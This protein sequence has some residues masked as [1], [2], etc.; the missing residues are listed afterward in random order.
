MPSAPDKPNKTALVL[1]GGGSLGAVQVGMLKALTRARVQYEFIVGASVGALNGAF[2]AGQPDNDGVNALEAAWRGLR[3]QD[4]FPLTLLRGLGGLLAYHSAASS[5]IGLVQLI[6]RVLPYDRLEQTRIPFTVIATDLLSGEEVPLSQGPAEAALLASTAIPAVFP[7]VRIGD[8]YLA[9]GG[10]ANNTPISAA[11]ALGATHIIVV[12]TGFSCALKEPPRGVIAT[13]LHALN[14]MIARQL[15]QD[16]RYYRDRADIIVVPPLC[17]LEVNPFDFS[18]TDAL[19]EK[20][21]QAAGAWLQHGGLE[22]SAV[23][24][25]L[26]PHRH[27]A[28]A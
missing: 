11:L 13:A 27:P 8:R 19:I 18:Q 6:R 23:P 4:I 5:P 14:L 21:D 26:L 10:I 24:S 17:P 15:L 1:A 28:M 2:L 25:A 12:P 22:K 7:P 20:A 9:D 16:M 3:R